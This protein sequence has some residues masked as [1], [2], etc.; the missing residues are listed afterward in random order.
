MVLALPYA[1]LAALAL[2]APALA[3]VKRA[4]P[5]PDHL[6]LGVEACFGRVYDTAQLREHPKQRVT[7]FHLLRVFTPDTNSEKGPQTRQEMLDAEGGEGGIGLTA[8][9]RLRD[10]KGVYSN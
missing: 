10:R 8:Y 4:S 1:L 5:L 2:A 6:P 7:S 3:E 9:V